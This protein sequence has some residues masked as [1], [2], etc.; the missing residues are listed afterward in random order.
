MSEPVVL[1][2]DR[3]AVAVVTIN[4]PKVLNALNAEVME[5][6]IALLRERGSRPGLRAIVITGAGDRSFVA[7]AD[8]A[9]MASFTAEQAER[10]AAMGHTLGLTIEALPVPVIA[11]VHGDAL[12]GGLGLVAA[13]DLAVADEGARLGTPEIK[14][15]LFP[16]IITAVLQRIVSRRALLELM[17]TGDRID[18]ARAESLGLVNRVAPA[19]RSLEV[20]LELADKVAGQSRA[21]LALGKRSFYEAADLPLHSAL[22]LLTGRLTV[23]M[24]TEDAMEG[25]AAFLG[26]RPP[27]WKHR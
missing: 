24:L 9:G 8:I 26:R 4:R 12:G 17:F 21:I 15:G 20:A 5:S 11:A 7:G 18:A 3:D 6:L 10:F 23:N 2:E 16:Y 1:W 14:V 27:E 22:E 19:G 13:C 25:V